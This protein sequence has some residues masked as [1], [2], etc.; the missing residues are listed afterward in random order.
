MCPRELEREC[1]V[2]K[3]LVFRKHQS[4]FRLRGESKQE[5][6]HAWRYCSVFPTSLFC[7][8]YRDL[9]SRTSI[10][11]TSVIRSTEGTTV[12]LLNTLLGLSLCS[13][14]VYLV[15]RNS[16][17]ASTLRE[18]R[19]EQRQLWRAYR[20]KGY[21]YGDEMSFTKALR[22]LRHLEEAMVVSNN[23]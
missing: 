2:Y 15:S 6:A 5:V 12:S 4:P 3:L 11:S 18:I 9:I 16:I 7:C 1:S 20:L 8:R 14:R 23:E 22:A 13:V 10:V 21:C 17:H 19:K